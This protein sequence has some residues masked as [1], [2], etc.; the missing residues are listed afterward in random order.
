MASTDFRNEPTY[1]NPSAFFEAM[2][3]T[4][5]A[6][7]NTDM[8][9]YDTPDF[10]SFKPDLKQAESTNPL[11]N[12]SEFAGF[13]LD[14]GY[15][16]QPSQFGSLTSINPALSPLDGNQSCDT[17]YVSQEGSP[18]NSPVGISAMPFE[19]TRPSNTH[20]NAS[21]K[22]RKRSSTSSTKTKQP[23][24]K[25][26]RKARRTSKAASTDTTAE[27]TV[28]DEKREQFLARNREAASKCRQKKKEW[29]QDLEQRARDLAA[30]KQMLTTYLAMLKNELL[31]LKC[32]CL[33]HSDCDCEAI[34]NY[35]KSTVTTMPP[36][37]TALYTK[38]SD[39][40]ANAISGE[41]ARK[42]SC[43]DLDAMSP[44]DLVSSPDSGEDG[45]GFLNLQAEVDASG[46]D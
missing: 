26:P 5:S 25:P 2:D 32:K 15:W 8:L 44:S 7:I 6:A 11:L 45:A 33:E 12:T 37:N 28:D 38:L 16:N 18:D 3:Y 46:K 4:D 30:Q 43:I 29:T 24:T 20:E 40:D 9:L 34:R 39:K 41:I 14:T 19:N 42:Q 10:D 21:I 36:A 23:E 31:M 27:R 35:L 1:D 13:N 22:A 17:G